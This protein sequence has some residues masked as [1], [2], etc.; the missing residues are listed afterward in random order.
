MADKS[1]TLTQSQSSSSLGV[2]CRGYVINSCDN[3]KVD[4]GTWS[5]STYDGIGVSIDENKITVWNTNTT[6]SS[7]SNT[8]TWTSSKVSGCTKTLSVTAEGAVVTQKCVEFSF[9]QDTYTVNFS[10]AGHIVTI[11]L[12]ITNWGNITE[13]NYETWG[14]SGNHL[15]ITSSTGTAIIKTKTLSLSKT[16]FSIHR[17][18]ILKLNPDV[19]K[20]YIH[21]NPRER[22]HPDVSSTNKNM[23]VLCIYKNFEIEDR[24]NIK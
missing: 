12:N 17:K 21:R 1:I 24:K 16:S 22:W 9:Q 19:S 11:T 10:A 7:V 15:S 4:D 5:P 8:F 14:E 6:G 23:I 13:E 18:D 3:S 20:T 2:T